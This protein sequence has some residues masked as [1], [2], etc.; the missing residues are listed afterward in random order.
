M[1]ACW[2]AAAPPAAI[3]RDAEAWRARLMTA[4]RNANA[5]LVKA[6]DGWRDADLDRYRLPHP[7]LG[8]LSI[9]EMA[10]FALYHGVHHVD[11]VKRRSASR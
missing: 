3:P 5:S 2:H 11:N 10:L 1:P 7:L 6:L 4:H 9:R 8:R